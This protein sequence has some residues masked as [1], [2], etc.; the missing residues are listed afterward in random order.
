MISNTEISEIRDHLENSQNPLFLFDNDADGLCSFAILRR[1]ID[2]GKGV[3]IKT[4]PEL[5]VQYLRKIDEFNPDAIFILDKAD[6]S[7]DFIGEVVARGLPIIWIDHHPSKTPEEVREQTF[8]YNSYPSAEPTTY[9]C[10]KVFNRQEDLWLAMVGCISDVYKPDFAEKF[11]ESYP[12]LYNSELS[13]FAA[14]HSTEIGKF[15]FML[16]FGLMNTTTNVVKM[17]KYLLK[18]SAPYELLEENSWT[19]DFHKRYSELKSELDALVLRAREKV[20][21]DSLLL[22]SYSGKTSMSS[23]LASRLY[24][25]NPDKLLV[26]AYKSPEKINIS[27]RGIGAKGLTEKVVQKIDGATGGG[28]EEATGAM[29]P[30]DSWEEFVSVAK[31]FVQQ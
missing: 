11:A 7:K 28:H 16:N 3:A 6:V 1:A 2:R 31:E 12:E 27:I 5:S 30:A 25:E 17:M 10:Q 4:Y 20:S 14:L 18:I 15:T 8:Y 26:V 19:V 23:I 24:F 29:I 21:D 9:I 13:A 22:F